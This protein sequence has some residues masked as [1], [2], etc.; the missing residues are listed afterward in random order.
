MHRIISRSPIARWAPLLLLF[1]SAPLRAGIVINEVAF[2]EPSGSPDWV[3]LYNPG[4]GPSSVDGWTLDDEDAAAGNEAVLSFP[5]LLPAGGFLVVYMDAA[6]PADADFSDGRGAVYSGT[7]TTVSLASTEDELSLRSPGGLVDF[8]AWVTDGSYGGA[9]DQAE[10]VAAGKWPSGGVVVLADAGSGYSIA[11]TADGLD[12]D[13]PADFSLSASPTPGFTNVPPVVPVDRAKPLDVVINEVAWGGTEASSSHEWME[14]FNASARSF[15]LAGWR[16]TSGDG[17]V[18]ATLSGVLA[19]GDFYL[20]ERTSDSPVGGRAADSFY[21]GSLPNEGKDLFLLDASS[22]VV[23]A[24]RFA[25]GWPG[26]SGAPEYRSMERVVASSGGSLRFNWRSNDGAVRNGTDAA[27]RPLNGTPGARNS[28]QSLSLPSASEEALTV[29]PSANPFSPRDRDPSRRAA[30]ILFNAGSPEAVKTLRLCDVRGE[31]VRIFSDADGLAGL[32]SGFVL[33]DGTDRD[34]R[35]LPT[36]IYVAHFE[37]VDP[38]GSRR[39]GRGT[40]VLG[41]PR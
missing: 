23:D 28:A 13:V 8:L 17:D 16:V 21:S 38:S 12:G 31:V 25:S 10:A 33:W 14:L 29:D 2:D 1:L 6:G 30:R 34:G 3:E 24:V 19:P 36:G 11:R 15:S 39:R 18:E 4:P 32:S 7:T 35:L 5:A 37:A 20:L 27:G 40:V 41:Y 26:G 9:A 22:G